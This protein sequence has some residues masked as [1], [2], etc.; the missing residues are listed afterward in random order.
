MLMRVAAS[1][2]D[3]KNKILDCYNLMS[4]KYTYATPTLYNAGMKNGQFASCFLGVMAD[5]S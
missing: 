3:D 5:D 2:H 1:L 4:S